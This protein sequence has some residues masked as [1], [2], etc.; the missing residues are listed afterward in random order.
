MNK[1]KNSNK[2]KTT[3]IVELDQTI[4]SKTLDAIYLSDFC[5][6]KDKIL[7][8]E[9]IDS[10][11][12]KENN[13][14][15]RYII[16]NK[17]IEHDLVINCIILIYII[18]SYPQFNHDIYVTNEDIKFSMCAVKDTIATISNYLSSEVC[19][20]ISVFRKQEHIHKLFSTYDY[21][22]DEK[23]IPLFKSYS[24]QNLLQKKIYNSF[25]INS[26]ISLIIGNLNELFFDLD[27][28]SDISSQ[29][30]EQ[31]EQDY[32]QEINIILNNITYKHNIRV[33]LRK[34]EIVSFVSTGIVHFFNKKI[35]LSP[36]E[37][38]AYL[39]YMADLFEN[40]NN[41]DVKM[42]EQNIIEQL[43]ENHNFS[44][45][46]SNGIVMTKTHADSGSNNFFVVQD[47]VF[48]D[49]YMAMFD[50]LWE[51]NTVRINHDKS[52]IIDFLNNMSKYSELMK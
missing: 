24:P 23:S 38:T 9:I 30:F 17:G 43:P 18:I 40:N 20:S 10:F 41:I 28:F 1:L 6:I 45:Y 36:I 13:S 29:Y 26:N 31:H 35:V 2:F 15:I 39:K 34:V 4:K 42:I 5:Y 14:R 12:H 46:V 25:I 52:Q 51:D 48:Q 3:D 8:L 16:T 19:L 33:L 47:R 27:M 50:K 22:L 7:Y 11:S 44:L 37:R 32:L 49:S 21:F